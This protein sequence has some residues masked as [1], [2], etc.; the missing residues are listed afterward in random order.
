M[1]GC[2]HLT[3][4]ILHGLYTSS[5]SIILRLYLTF[6]NGSPGITRQTVLS[7]HSFNAWSVKF[8]CLMLKVVQSFWYLL[9]IIAIIFG[10]NDFYRIF[11]RIR[12]IF[13]Q[14]QT[15]CIIGHF[16]QYCDNYSIPIKQCVNYRTFHRIL[17]QFY[18]HQTVC[19]P[20]CVLG[21]FT[22]FRGED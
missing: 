2:C 15:V 18:Q 10:K 7:G 21:T 11:Y 16:T 13:Y 17:R 12:D 8:R 19:P 14:Y 4:R 1:K 6:Y 5:R 22:L 9:Y 3:F 20:V